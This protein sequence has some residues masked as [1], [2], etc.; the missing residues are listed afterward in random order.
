MLVFC[1]HPRVRSVF[2]CS[3][4]CPQRA[5]RSTGQL[6]SLLAVMSQRS[7]TRL[8]VVSVLFFKGVLNRSFVFHQ[9]CFMS[10]KFRLAV[11]T[12]Q[13]TVGRPRR[14]ANAVCEGKLRRAVGDNLPSL[15]RGAD[16]LAHLWRAWED[17]C[18]KVLGLRG[19]PSNVRV[20]AFRWRSG[21][22]LRWFL[23][24]HAFPRLLPRVCPSVTVRWSGR[25][26]LT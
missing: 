14:D 11:D 22:Y 3:L 8:C 21:P 2:S 23:H 16:P 18:G 1:S 24:D 15:V 12:V 20:T 26:F 13:A 4:C 7:I 6:P 5:V 19:T 9:K 10:K 25:P 17:F